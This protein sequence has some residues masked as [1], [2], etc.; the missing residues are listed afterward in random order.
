MR[1][2]VVDILTA[3][4]HFRPEMRVFTFIAYTDEEA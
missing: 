3:Q 4:N 1:H 2:H